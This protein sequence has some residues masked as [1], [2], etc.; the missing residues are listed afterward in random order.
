M[1]RTVLVTGGTGLLGSHLIC[2]LLADGIKVRAT[3]RKSSNRDILRKV[4][5][6]YSSAPGDQV[7][8]EWTECDLCNTESVRSAMTGVSIVYHCAASVSFEK[9]AGRSIID[10]NV[11]T[12]ANIVQ[13]CLENKIEKLC[14]VSSVAALGGKDGD[15]DVNEERIWDDSTEHSPYWTSKHLSELEVW[16]GISLGL[17]AVIVLP[18]VI[19]GPGDWTR[20]SAAIFGTIAKG[21]PFYTDGIKAYVDVNDVV[22]AMRLLIDSDIS[23]EKFIVSA[24]NLTNLSL[25]TM[26][27]RNLGVRSPSVKIPRALSPLILPSVKIIKL[28]SGKEIPLTRD[29]LR[30]AWTKVGFDNKKLRQRTGIAFTPIA[31]SVEEIASIYKKEK[32]HHA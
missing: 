2:S 11:K 28:L 30:A 3:Y 20:S 16:K 5:S 22:K 23:G 32:D 15:L 14:H 19:L 9:D 13:V 1:N 29:I 8:V 24:E 6:Y 17:K 10:N 31:R 26:I 4:K 12:T 7:D 18:S 27:A 21:L 25:F